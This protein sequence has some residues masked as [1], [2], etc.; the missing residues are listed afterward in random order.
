MSG[1]TVQLA[2]AHPIRLAV[3][4]TCDAG[5]L[6]ALVGPSG[7]GKTT[8][9]KTIAG[10]VHTRSGRIQ[11]GGVE[12]LDTDHGLVLPPQARRVGLV[13]QSY[14]LFPHLSALDNVAIAVSGE[15]ARA[16]ARD[17]LA[18]V[19]LAGLEER[20]PGAL[21]GGQQ[22]RVALA[23]ALA[24]DPAVLLLDE[25]FSAV[26]QATRQTL[27]RELA[28]LRRSLSL[29]IVLVTHDLFEAR[30]LA[31]R[32]VILDHGETMQSGTPGHV[33]SRP[34]NAR[35]AKLLGIQNHFAGVFRSAPDGEAWGTLQWGEKGEGVRLRTLDKRRIPDGQRV[36]W[37]IA[38]EYLM[39]QAMADQRADTFACRLEDVLPL[40]EM[41]QCKVRVT[42]APGDLVIMNVPTR[43]L[44]DHGLAVG[45]AVWVHLDVAGI[46]IMPTRD[47][48]VPRTRRD[49]TAGL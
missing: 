16:R 45:M 39:L 10:L 49:R 4:F 7:S 46:H 48:N 19:N 34:R 8:I 11:A 22:Q 24:R 2:Q 29:P 42:A 17:L 25:P 33:L 41:T 14:A 13:F 20:R 28:E 40:G 30:M 6:L 37:V 9:L 35:V 27:Y 23:R 26:D 36:T 12:W 32:M 15:G 47:P 3:E 31:D 18:R 38:G 5:E 1:L 21:S 43:F 44:A